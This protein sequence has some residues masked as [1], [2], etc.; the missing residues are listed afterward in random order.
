[1]PLRRRSPFGKFP[2]TRNWQIIIPVFNPPAGLLENLEK[3]E[4]ASPGPIA[5]LVLVDD[6]TTT[7]IPRHAEER[8]YDRC[9]S[10]IWRCTFWPACLPDKL[11]YCFFPRN[12][13]STG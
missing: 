7:D 9:V 6:G 4:A 5:R 8:E 12:S 13:N 2:V 3:L 1:M 11:R 10:V